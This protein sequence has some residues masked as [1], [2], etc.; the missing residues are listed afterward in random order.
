MDYNKV[1]QFAL[2]LNLAIQAV[3]EEDSDCHIPSEEL[4][5]FAT[6]FITAIGCVTPAMMYNHLT[7]KSAGNYLA[8]N[9]IANRL[10]MQLSRSIAK[11]SK[12]E[13]E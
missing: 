12:K 13:E 3:F 11:D 9:H 2:T 5:E 4:E 6:E 1:Q 10:C 7:G 8:F